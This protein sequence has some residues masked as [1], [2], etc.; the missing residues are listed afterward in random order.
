MTSP[1]PIGSLAVLR[2]RKRPFGLQVQVASIRPLTRTITVPA[3]PSGAAGRLGCAFSAARARPWQRAA[4]VLA[5]PVA[6]CHLGKSRCTLRYHLRHG[7]G[8]GGADRRV[9]VCLGGSSG[10]VTVAAS[11]AGPASEVP[12]GSQCHSSRVTRYYFQSACGLAA[13]PDQAP[14]RASARSLSASDI[15]RGPWM[16]Q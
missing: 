12:V 6:S 3:F 9:S 2:R 8:T 10:T 11:D 7:P 13:H 15:S 16:C 14:N 4:H 1:R 5:V